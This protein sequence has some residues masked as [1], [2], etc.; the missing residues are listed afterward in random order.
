MTWQCWR[1]AWRGSF[2]GSVGGEKKFGFHQAKHG[3]GKL[4][5]MGI[6]SIFLKQK[7]GLKLHLP[8]SYLT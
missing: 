8:S 1:G 7:L 6:S 5:R 2:F 4:S 3:H